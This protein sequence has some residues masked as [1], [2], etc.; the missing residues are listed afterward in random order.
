MSSVHAPSRPDWV[1]FGVS[2]PPNGVALYASSTLSQAELD[3]HVEEVPYWEEVD[4]FASRAP[5]VRSFSIRSVMA[6]IVCVVAPDYATA[7]RRLLTEWSPDGHAS[8]VA[9][10][11]R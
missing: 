10:P 8:Q 2:C 5:L 3:A 11:S 4:A 9:L 1:M 7:L 6:E